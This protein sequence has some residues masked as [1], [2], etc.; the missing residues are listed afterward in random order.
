MNAAWNATMTNNF[1]TEIFHKNFLNGQM[2][3]KVRKVHFFLFHTAHQ[4]DEEII[5]RIAIIIEVN[6]LLFAIMIP[7]KMNGTR[8]GTLV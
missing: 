1:R 7:V 6:L 8:F 3:R 4:L 2:P 5:P